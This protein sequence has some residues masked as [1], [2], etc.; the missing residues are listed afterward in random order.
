MTSFRGTA[1][2][3]LVMVAYYPF[4]LRE[5]QIPCSSTKILRKQVLTCVLL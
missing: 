1:A 4:R 5:S 3:V 2:L